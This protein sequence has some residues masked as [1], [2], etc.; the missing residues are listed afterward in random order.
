MSRAPA[1]ERVEDSPMRCVAHNRA[2]KPCGRF[3][4][5]GGTVCATHGGSIQRVK[6]AARRRLAEQVARQQLAELEVEPLGNPLDELLALA[7]REKAIEAWFAAK[8]SALDLDDMRYRSDHGLE[9]LRAELALWERARDRLG[10]WLG[11][12]I[13]LGLDEKKARLTE[14]QARIIG[15]MFETLL[16]RLELSY[17]QRRVAPTIMRELLSIEAAAAEVGP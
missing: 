14:V 15:D 12:L 6:A 13:R 2:G 9:Q 5:K 7:A 3:A 16:D 4:I 11:S 1:P 10:R 8:V 17:E